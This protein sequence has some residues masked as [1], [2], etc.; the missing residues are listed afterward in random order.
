MSPEDIADRNFNRNFNI[1][2]TKSNQ[3]GQKPP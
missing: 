1:S 3:T 2:L